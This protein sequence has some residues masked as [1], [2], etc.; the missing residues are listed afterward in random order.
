MT[1]EEYIHFTRCP[2]YVPSLLQSSLMNNVFNKF[3]LISSLLVPL[4]YE[5]IMSNFKILLLGEMLLEPFS[6]S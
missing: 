1:L 3:I 6:S 5:L 4:K 2:I